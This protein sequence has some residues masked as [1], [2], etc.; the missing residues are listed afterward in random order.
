MKRWG[1]LT[2]SN[3]W[4]AAMVAGMA[5][6]TLARAAALS[7]DRSNGSSGAVL[8]TQTAAVL[9]RG[10]EGSAVQELQAMLALL[11]Y[12][13]GAVDG[14]YGDATFAAVSRFQVDA[15]LVADGVVGPSTWQRLLP[16]P[17]SLEQSSPQLSP[18]ATAESPGTTGQP[19]T[20]RPA[21]SSGTAGDLPILRLDD[22]SPDVSMLQQRLKELG[23]YMGLV[24]GDFGAQTEEAVQQFQRQAGLEADGVVGPATWTELLK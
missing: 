7:T 2:I 16:T 20:V 5:M 15:G 21:V 9:E 11:G 19:G 10:S 22:L 14:L 18:G 6:P 12:Y 13:S 23:F 24:D 3:L 17:S 8:I 4:W 1:L